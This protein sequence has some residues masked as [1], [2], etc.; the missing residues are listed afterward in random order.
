MPEHNPMRVLNGRYPPHS[1]PETRAIN[2]QNATPRLVGSPASIISPLAAR[3]VKWDGTRPRVLTQDDMETPVKAFLSSNVTPRSGSRKS[4]I[5]STPSSPAGTPTTTPSRSKASSAVNANGRVGGESQ[6]TYTIGS[7]ERETKQTG[8]P[9]SLVSSGKGSGFSQGRAS[10]EREIY[11]R[12]GASPERSHNSY[13]RIN[14][15]LSFSSSVSSQ[16]PKSQGKTAGFLYANGE[17]E[18][19]T[20]SSSASATSPPE[21]HQ[22]K[23]FHAS[24]VQAP[25]SLQTNLKLY[26]T[27]QSSPTSSPSQGTFSP[28]NSYHTRRPASPLKETKVPRKDSISTVNSWPTAPPVSTTGVHRQNPKPSG[29]PSPVGSDASRRSSPRVLPKPV[30]SHGKSSS[31]N[32]LDQKSQRRTSLN[33]VLEL[34]LPSPEQ[35]RPIFVAEPKPISDDISS[36]PPSSPPQPQT[37]SPSKLGS[38]ESKLDHL[39]ELAAN[40]RRERKVL[41]LE[42]SNSSLLAI[43]RTLERE[44][45]KQNAELR[46]YRRLEHSGRLSITPSNRLFSDHN[47]LSAVTSTTEATSDFSGLSGLDDS[48]DLDLDEDEAENFSDEAL[49]QLDFTDPSSPSPATHLESLARARVR[50]K[51]VETLDLTRFQ[52]MLIDSQKMNQSLRRCLDCT[53]ELISEGRKA[54]DYKVPTD[55][56]EEARGGRVLSPDEVEGSVKRGRS[57]LSPAAD[58]MSDPLETLEMHSPDRH[59]LRSP[60][61]LDGMNRS[62]DWPPGGSEVG[63]DGG[64]T[65][66]SEGPQRQTE[67]EPEPRTPEPAG[68]G[69]DGGSGLM[70]LGF[71]SY[72]DT[73]GESWGL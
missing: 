25:K 16:T 19:E 64:D 70:G 37:P 61:A 28:A 34:M 11:D 8:R 73:L 50:Q 5:E 51:K 47:R 38:T 1:T 66:R 62:P 18:G 58:V 39:N 22:P 29:I 45:H 26:A 21:T 71:K 17:E 49:S 33:M 63:S 23:F 43:N 20:E 41:D 12:K 55:E 57:L 14:G 59:G 48:Y 6:K 9:R 10:P 65:G 56:L 24:T 15:R 54:L 67:A 7:R 46:R 2:S 53:E 13:T 36:S 52:A 27:P 60:L 30:I 40:A 68:G 32:S 4:R 44:M 31:I 3:D 35:S 42:I 72:I 69:S